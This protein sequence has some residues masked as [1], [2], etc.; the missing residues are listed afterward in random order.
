MRCDAARE[1]RNQSADHRTV[2]G[3]AVPSR[4]AQRD[5]GNG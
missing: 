5:G 1:V 2:I 4:S 3:A